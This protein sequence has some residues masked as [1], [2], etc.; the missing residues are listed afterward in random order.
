QIEDFELAGKPASRLDVVKDVFRRFVRGDGKLEGR[1][2]DLIGLV[3][4]A[5]F[6]DVKCPLTLSHEALEHEI[7]AVRTAIPSDDGTNIGEAVAWGL[8]DLKSVKAK[9]K[10]MIL[11]T[12]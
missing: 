11:L 4:F 12:D 5:N 6:P 3:T 7:A 1:P 8:E 2:N 10:V 9:S